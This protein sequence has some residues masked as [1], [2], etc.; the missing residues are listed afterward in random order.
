[1][2]WWSAG[3][4]IDRPSGPTRK[5]SHSTPVFTAMPF[6]AALS[7]IDF[8]TSR[9][10]WPTVAPSIISEEAS[11]P[12]S[13]FHGSWIRLSGSGTAN[14]SALAG[15]MSSQVAKPAKPAPAVCIPS[16]AEAGTSLA[17]SVPNRSA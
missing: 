16:I 2:V 13:G 10:P 5:N 7:T 15:D 8:R 6:A 9:G 4:E 1:L 12:T 14:M 3:S 17:L 11:Q